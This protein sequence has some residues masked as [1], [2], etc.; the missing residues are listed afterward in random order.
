MHIRPHALLMDTVAVSS[1]ESS[2]VIRDPYQR[3]RVWLRGR[4]AGGEGSPARSTL[5][6]LVNMASLVPDLTHLV[7][8]LLAD[9]AVPPRR[10]ARLAAA[11]A[12]RLSPVDL[13]PELLLGPLGWLDDLALFAWA[14]EGLLGDVPA[15]VLERHWAGSP[16]GLQAVRQA[17]AVTDEVLGAGLIGKAM[18]VA[19]A[20]LRMA[21]ILRR[22]AP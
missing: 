13:V 19:T 15:E 9:P 7:I 8:R 10:K 18:Q 20:P 5:S 6:A 12:W 1:E 21:K 11:L 4:V 22:T 3:W 14:L 2:L 16:S 17:V